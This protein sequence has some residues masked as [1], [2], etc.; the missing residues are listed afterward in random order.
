MLFLVFNVTTR[1]SCVISWKKTELS[2]SPCAARRRDVKDT[3]TSKDFS[4]FSFV[5]TTSNATTEYCN[6]SSIISTWWKATESLCNGGR[7]MDSSRRHCREFC[8]IFW[9]RSK[10][11]SLFVLDPF[12]LKRTR[13]WMMLLWIH[14]KNSAAFGYDSSFVIDKSFLKGALLIMRVGVRSKFKLISLVHCIGGSPTIS[15][16][17]LLGLIINWKMTGFSL[18]HGLYFAFGHL[19]GVFYIGISHHVRGRTSQRPCHCWSRSSEIR[20]PPVMRDA[21]HG[22]QSETLPPS[23]R[24]TPH[25]T[26]NFPCKYFANVFFMES[27]YGTISYA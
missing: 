26:D 15:T 7:T 22:L 14:H 20:N 16:T 13:Q 5:F 18:A 19:S 17:I 4:T 21:E 11:G 6:D 9:K 1:F 2:L 25:Q 3:C 12:S 24:M 23:L 8:E 10:R 27:M